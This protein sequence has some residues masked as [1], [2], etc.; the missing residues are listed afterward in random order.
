MCSIDFVQCICLPHIYKLETIEFLGNGAELA[1]WEPRCHLLG[2][3]NWKWVPNRMGG[4]RLQEWT[5]AHAEGSP[6]LYGDV[7]N[8]LHANQMGDLCPITLF[9]DGP[10]ISFSV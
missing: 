4:V 1:V 5:V 7:R 10:T 6:E 2:R 8:A 3:Q 9:L